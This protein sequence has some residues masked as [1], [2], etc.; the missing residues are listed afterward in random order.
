MFGL[1]SSSACWPSSDPTS[2]AELD[3]SDEYCGGLNS[4]YLNIR[5]DQSLMSFIDNTKSTH[6]GKNSTE[7]KAKGWARVAEFSSFSG[8]LI[9]DEFR[10]NR[11]WITDSLRMTFRYEG[12][13]R[14]ELW[15]WVAGGSSWSGDEWGEINPAGQ[16]IAGLSMDFQRNGVLTWSITVEPGNEDRP[17]RFTRDVVATKLL[18]TLDN[19]T[20]MFTGVEIVNG[21]ALDSDFLAIGQYFQHCVSAYRGACGPRVLVRACNPKH[22]NARHDTLW[23]EIA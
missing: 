17:N 9:Q 2:V 1:K 7:I 15:T 8:R 22:H 21:A 4:Q 14:G 18:G 12:W 6:T 20:E 23:P 16:I 10:G 5:A 3:R 11:V 19:L 13:T